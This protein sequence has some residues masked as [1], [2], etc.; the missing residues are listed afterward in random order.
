MNCATKRFNT[1][2]FSYF[3]VNFTILTFAV[4]T[5]LYLKDFIVEV[6]LKGFAVLRVFFLLLELLVGFGAGAA[7]RPR[8]LLLCLVPLLLLVTFDL[9][10]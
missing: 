3:T 5:V 10:G 8:A 9:S 6:I 1:A 7:S 4:S 2:L